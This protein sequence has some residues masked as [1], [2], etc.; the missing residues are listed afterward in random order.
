[1]Q[2]KRFLFFSGLLYGLLSVNT[3]QSQQPEK[4]WNSPDNFFFHA[5]I[6]G[7]WIGLPKPAFC[8]DHP[9]KALIA[10]ALSGVSGYAAKK[11]YDRHV[12]EEAQA[13]AKQRVHA[14]S[15]QMHKKNQEILYNELKRQ[16]QEFKERMEERN[17][18]T[19]SNVQ[20]FAPGSI[21]ETF[22]NVAGMEAV[23]E[24]LQDILKYFNDPESFH[25]IGATAPKGILLAGP[26]GVGKTLIARALAGEARCSFL[27]V[28]GSQFIEMFVGRGAARVRD[29]FKCAREQGPCIIFIDEIDSI[30]QSRE[31]AGASGA[32]SERI[33]TLNQLL[34]EMD[35]FN[36]QENPIIII[37]ATNRASCLDPAILRPGRFDKTVTVNLPGIVDRRKIIAVHLKKVIHENIDID[38]I[39][40][41]TVGLSGAQIAQLVNEAALIALR[42]GDHTVT[43]AHLDESRDVILLGGK[44]TSE[45]FE[46]TKEDL[47]KTAIHEAGH[48][49][50]YVLEP[51]ALP[52]YKVTI[53]PRGGNLGTTFGMYDRDPVSP[54]KEQMLAYIR[55]CLGGSVAE[56]IGLKRR[57]SGIRGDLKQAR[58][59]AKQMV[60]IYGM[61]KEYKDVSFAEY[62]G[63]EAALP[64]HV[65]DALQKEIANIIHESREHVTRVLSKHTQQLYEVARQLM[66]KGTL[67]GYEVYKICGVPE[68][69]LEYTF[70]KVP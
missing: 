12:Q 5:S 67:Y 11:I 43:M 4:P 25:A 26:P 37:G 3:I 8:M 45:T 41:G 54:N 9:G 64:T 70:V 22:D 2:S 21:S 59:Q 32:D 27:Y 52:L 42:R 46:L 18:D 10:L 35:G 7:L 29:L 60:M 65:S 50:M 39:A 17:K 58:S 1:M 49:L 53:R 51:D 40:R 16:S 36:V 44:E 19:K 20:I 47:W 30:A 15:K 33:Q 57:G 6:G 48:A 28:N 62:I 69:S 66:E 63:R 38:L 34:A 55:V 13:I 31:N 61:S 23:K 68:P 14:L 24:D 56:E